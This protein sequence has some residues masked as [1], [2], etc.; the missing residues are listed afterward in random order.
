LR[1]EASG[2]IVRT[3]MGRSSE[4]DPRW[5][6][7]KKTKIRCASCGSDHAG[8]FD[9]GMDMPEVWSGYR[10]PKDNSELVRGTDVL[11]EDFC[12]SEGSFFVRC[13][14]PLPIVG[15]DESFAYGV[16]SSL[17]EKNFWKYV[18]TF[19]SGEQGELGP[20]FGW[21]SNRLKGYPETLSLKCHVHPRSERKRPWLELEPTDHPLSI[22]SRDGITLTRL[23]EIYAMHGHD[24]R[25][26][27]APS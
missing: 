15:T 2:G 18:E 26:A 27:F 5:P 8:V 11:T 21:F 10:E 9:L 20:W 3:T 12:I 23:F 14:L 16:W 24:V 22:E 4:Q 19:D 6:A 25:P 13:V 1:P 7:F 17:S